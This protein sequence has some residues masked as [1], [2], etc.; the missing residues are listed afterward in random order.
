MVQATTAARL[1]QFILVPGYGTLAAAG[2]ANR[3]LAKIGPGT[4]GIG[5]MTQGDVPVLI[6]ETAIVEVDQEKNYGMNIEGRGDSQIR[7]LHLT[8]GESGYTDHAVKHGLEFGVAHL[9]ADALFTEEEYRLDQIFVT[10]KCHKL[11]QVIPTSC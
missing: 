5:Q 7:S 1:P 8:G 6:G 11:P 9:F 4:G 10:A 2:Q 3:P